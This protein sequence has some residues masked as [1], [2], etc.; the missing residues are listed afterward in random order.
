ML[1]AA[2]AFAGRLVTIAKETIP[3]R[4]LGEET[5]DASRGR[6]TSQRVV[7]PAVVIHKFG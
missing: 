2:K 1:N 3:K 4:R 6:Q 5:G 7:Y